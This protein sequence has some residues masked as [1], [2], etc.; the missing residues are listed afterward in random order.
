MQSALSLSLSLSLQFSLNP[1]SL[2]CRKKIQERHKTP[3]GEE[4]EEKA[5]TV[6]K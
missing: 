2:N 6:S 4:E 5:L 3:P 1:G